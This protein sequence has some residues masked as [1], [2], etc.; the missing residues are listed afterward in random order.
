MFEAQQQL[1]C[2]CAREAQ[3]TGVVHMLRFEEAAFLLGVLAAEHEKD[4]PR[5]PHVRAKVRNRSQWEDP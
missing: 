2:N 4:L 1:A 5:V 3:L